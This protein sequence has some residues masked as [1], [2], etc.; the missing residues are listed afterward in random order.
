MTARFWGCLFAVLTISGSVVG[1]VAGQTVPQQILEEIQKA[2]DGLKGE[3]VIG[4]RKIVADETTRFPF[5]R[6]IVIGELAVVKYVTRNGVSTALVIQPQRV[7]AVDISDGPHVIWKDATTAEVITMIKGQVQRTVYKDLTKPRVVML[8]QG[9]F[10]NSI[11]LDPQKPVPPKSAWAAPSRLMAISDLEGNYSNART[12]LRNNGVIDKN[13]RWSYK[14]GHLALVGDIVDRGAM[15]TELQWLLR[16]LEREAQAAGGQVHYVL[17]NHEVMVMG[18]DLRYIHPKYHFV[19][20]RLGIRYDKLYGPDS[21]IGRWWR[22]KNGVQRVGDL[23]F[24]HGGYSPRLDAAALDMQVLNKRIRAGLPPARPTGQT[25]ATNPVQ[26]QHGP[27]WYRGYFAAHAASWGGLATQAQINR[28]L[29]RHQ[30]KHIVVG[31]TVVSEVGPL[32]AAGSVIGIDVKWSD[33]KSCQGLLYEKD[34]LWRVT[35]TGQREQ[36]FE[37]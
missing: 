31:H 30:A 11:T 8:P 3:W 4:G 36:L 13:D 17:G 27:F 35:M 6:K 9:A 1:Q 5:D 16:R 15:V 37:N 22:S 12:F 2:P 28:I 14:D 34:K 20:A 21:D 7:K 32:N 25:A 29:E 23:L 24:V 26:H 19:M 33:S 18:G 10:E